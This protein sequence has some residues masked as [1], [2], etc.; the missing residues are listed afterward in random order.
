[1]VSNTIDNILYDKQ[2]ITN[3]LGP[4]PEVTPVLKTFT[5]RLKLRNVVTKIVS[6]DTTNQFI[7]GRDNWGTNWGGTRTDTL[8]AVIP[9]NNIF[10][11]YFGQDDYIDTVNSTGT[12]NTTNE[13]YTLDNLEVLQT[14]VIA[15]LREPITSVLF[16]EHDDFVNGGM[17]LPFT[18]GVSTFG[19]GVTIQASNDGGSNW[20]TIT[21]GVKYTFAS[22]SSSDELK[23]KLINN[24]TTITISKPIYI[25]VNK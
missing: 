4:L 12:L 8:Y 16:R 18:L 15:K 7:W 20:F 21:E 1:M 17:I 11:E 24:G 14:E 10:V 22:S 13:T 9:N 3:Q 6:G 23:V 19:M 2:D 25:E 5:S